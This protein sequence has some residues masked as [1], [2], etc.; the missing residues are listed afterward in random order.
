M[1]SVYLAN[2]WGA[3]ISLGTLMTSCASHCPDRPAY[4]ATA[5]SSRFVVVVVQARQLGLPELESP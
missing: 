4:V 1:D 5:L 3:P 2:K